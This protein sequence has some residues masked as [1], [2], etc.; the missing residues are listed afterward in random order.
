[1]STSDETLSERRA[2]PAHR[3]VSADLRARLHAG[4]FAPDE[5]LPTEA[6]LEREYGV[7]RQTVR[8]AFQD[9]VAEG[10]VRRIPGRGT[11]PIADAA[12]HRYAR[13]VGSIED[14]MEWDDS[15]MDVIRGVSLESDAEMANRLELTSPVVAVLLLRRTFEG[16]AFGLSRIYLP[17]ETGQ[18][19]VA[20]GALDRDVRTVIRT[21]ESYLPDSIAG[22]Q[23]VITAVLADEEIASLLDMQPGAA[24]LR[25]ERTFFDTEDRPVEVA[26]THYDPDRYAYR[27]ELRGRMRS[28]V[29]D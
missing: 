4:A 2:G 19:L 9:L 25:V 8:R 24:A 22:V 6:E 17:P 23:Q 5:R 26:V 29:A 20:D 15:E 27:L 13:P 21:V 7:S 12:S 10:L 3:H 28:A 14:L 1:M 11:F 16:R 18:R